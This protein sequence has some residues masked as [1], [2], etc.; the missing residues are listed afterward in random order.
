MWTHIYIYIYLYSWSFYVSAF[1][2]LTIFKDIFCFRFRPIRSRNTRH[3]CYG[4]MVCILCSWYATDE[5]WWKYRLDSVSV[6]LREFLWLPSGP[7]K[8]FSPLWDGHW[9]RQSETSRIPEVIPNRQNHLDKLTYS[10]IYIYTYNMYVLYCVVLYCIV[11]VIVFVLY[12]IVLHYMVRMY[13]YVVLCHAM[14]CYVPFCYVI[15]WYVMLCYVMYAMQC[16]AMLCTYTFANT[17][18]IWSAFGQFETVQWHCSELI[19]S[20]HWM[21]HPRQHQTGAVLGHRK[22]QSFFCPG[23]KKHHFFWLFFR[24]F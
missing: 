21:V 9:S 11:I 8:T 18:R 17:S 16:N 13:C 15:L 12:C 22:F 6:I 10:H 23:M 3:R 5:R 20:W 1:L 19:Q 24:L 4:M 7:S 14:L 2:Y